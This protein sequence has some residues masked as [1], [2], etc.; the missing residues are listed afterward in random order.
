MLQ[1]WRQR[2]RRSFS[3]PCREARY[4][5]HV[6]RLRRIPQRVS[7]VPKEVQHRRL[8]QSHSRIRHMKEDFYNYDESGFR[9]GIGD[10]EWIITFNPRM[11]AC[12]PNQRVRDLVTC[13]GTI[14]ADEDKLPPIIILPAI[15]IMQNWISDDLLDDYLLAASDSGYSNDEYLLPFQ[16]CQ[17]LNEVFGA[18]GQVVF[19][20]APDDPFTAWSFGTR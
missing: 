17:R 16:M 2:L 10:G 15:Q 1:K 11:P 7:H 19:N 13:G 9:I 6:Q 3:I 20:L 4:S 8:W 14:S 12:T 5:A 18:F